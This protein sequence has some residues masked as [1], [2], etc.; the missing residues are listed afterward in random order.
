MVD[1]RPENLFSL[2][3]ILEGM[4]LNLVK[5]TS[6]REAL[7]QVLRED[8][9]LIL[10]DVRLPDI[11]G[12]EIAK[13]I[14][15]RERSRHTPIIFMTAY[16]AS[17]EQILRGYSVGGVDY[18]IKPFIPKILRYKVEVFVD[19][20]KKS[21]ALRRLNE[22]LEQQVAK[23]TAELRRAE[24][25]YRSL[26]QN[27]VEGIFQTTLDGRYL[28]IAN[29]AMAHILGYETPEQFLAS[30][31]DLDDIYLDSGRRAEFKRLIQQNHVV[32][33]FESQIRRRDGS[34]IW[35]S[36]NTG[37]F[38]DDRGQLLGY[39]GMIQDITERKQTDA[40]R[41][42]LEEQ[43][44][45]AQKMEAIGTLAGGVAHDF[46]NLLTVITGNTKLSQAE[47]PPDDPLQ[48]NLANIENAATR[49]TSLVRQLLAFSRHQQL[50][51]KAIDLNQT[52]NSSVKMLQPSLSK[53]VAV[54]V[55]TTPDLALVFADPVQIE[56]VMM[57]LVFNARDAM[58]NGG[59]LTVQTNQVV[60]SE[61]YCR[62]HT[63]AKPGRYV[64]LTITDTGSGMDAET[65]QHI[66]EPFFTTKEVGQGTGLGFSVIYG[67]IRQHD[68]LIEVDSKVGRGTSVKIYLPV[69]EPEVQ[70]D[71]R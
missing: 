53:Q 10:L 35:I 29:P 26:F 61:A 48:P 13:L 18:T 1:D 68:G 33:G 14:R 11:D 4:N 22:T 25:K 60:L 36:E 64:R 71:G 41:R 2:E 56:Q 69:V 66:F 63:W 55:R 42:H 21:E 27:A 50:E 3:T 38:C 51:R 15:E 31:T 44:L 49:A 28:V 45:Q 5:A 16:V 37:E 8:F 32:T 70:T 62:R 30:V 47:L 23:R 6:G 12:I 17:D 58:P 67:I 20:F 54:R 19:L 65:R 24:E 34:V 57:N 46:N 40:E 52:I 9:A 39:E 59:R 43:L 7:R